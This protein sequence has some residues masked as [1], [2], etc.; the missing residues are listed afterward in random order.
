MILLEDV[1]KSYNGRP[2]L[3]GITTSVAAGEFVYLTG[4]SGAGKSTFLRLLYRAELP[5][6]GRV[7]VAGSDLVGM[8][9]HQVAMFRRR[10][11]VVFQD[12]KLLRRR[13]VGENICFVLSLLNVSEREQQR[14]AYLTLK[15]LGLQ[16]RIAAYPDELSG[17]E[18]QRVAV[19]RALVCQPELI[20]ADEP[21]GNLDPERS[22]ELMELLKQ[23][24]YQGTTVL[25]AT[26]DRSLI[27]SHP[28]RTL[29]LERGRLVRDAWGVT[30]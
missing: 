29:T 4:A 13:T 25:V 16:H 2:A 19:A 5:D 12:F 10:L 23:I 3:R 27:A 11:G 18:Q 20:L 8:N 21:T 24:N 22:H 17:G 30:P 26:H 15:Q 6:Q 28:A 14:L 7:R 1:V 9:R